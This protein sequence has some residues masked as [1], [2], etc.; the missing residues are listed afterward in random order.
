MTVWTRDFRLW[1]ASRTTSVAG[2][3]A[4]AAV[5]PILVFQQTGSAVLTGA[6]SA[7]AVLPYLCF[8]LFAGALADRVSRKRLMVGSD[9]VSAA[10]LLSVP[11]AYAAG[12]GSTAHVLV[13]TFVVWAAFVW[14]D[15]AAWGAL[16]AVVGRDGLVRANSVIWSSGVVAAIA[17]PAVAGV[18]ASAAHPSAVLAADG[19]SYLVSAA[20]ILRIRT[21]L[22][23]PESPR[24]PLTRTIREGLEFIRRT[25]EV[26]V[27]T[28]AAVALTASS[29]AVAGMLVVHVGRDLGIGS[30]D[31]RVGLFFAAGAVGALLATVLLPVLSR[32]LGNGR[33]AVVAFAAYVPALLAVVVAGH[34]VV[35]LVTWAIWFCANTLAVTNGIT[36]R[37]RVTPDGLQ[38]RVNT[39][40]RMIAMG[41]TP[42][43]ALLGGV[44]AE[45]FGVR[46]TYLL[47]AVPVAVAALVLWRSP[48]RRLD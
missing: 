32:R 25:P 45:G 44:A 18:V 2:A 19:V 11:L 1:L 31:W 15:A 41:G 3:E 48:V 13:V 42:V 6:V 46:G 24:E 27:V 23:A 5:L 7:F 16:T 28:G 26:R 30:D 4:T 38:G 14:F 35:A 17:M 43:G 40:V 22:T 21:R 47:A 34:W 39:S 8:G 9:L 36:I 10:A 29:G 37:Q 33:V 20:L 12:A